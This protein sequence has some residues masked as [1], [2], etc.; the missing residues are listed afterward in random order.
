MLTPDDPGGI[1]H[2]LRRWFDADNGAVLVSGDFEPHELCLTVW[3][4]EP[5]KAHTV[6]G[7]TITEVV[8]AMRAELGEGFTLNQSAEPVV[9]EWVELKPAPRGLEFGELWSEKVCEVCLGTGVRGYSDTTRGQEMT[10]GTCDACDGT[11][12]QS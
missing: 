8:Q 12:T 4:G 1:L 10:Q 5:R 6:Y 3:R 11:G 7:D 9:L 2:D